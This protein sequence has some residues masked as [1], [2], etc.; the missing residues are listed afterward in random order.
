MLAQVVT[1]KAACVASKLGKGLQNPL[2]DFKPFY[3]S[4]TPTL[5]KVWSLKCILLC[6][7]SITSEGKRIQK[8]TDPS[9]SH[10]SLIIISI[11]WSNKKWKN[12][13]IYTQNGLK[14][15][16]HVSIKLTLDVFLF[17]FTKCLRMNILLTICFQRL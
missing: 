14:P 6:N 8:S 10:P 12:M 3:P 11:T 5:Q 15:I 17:T 13:R 7:I 9:A 4:P 1:A 16:T 2:K